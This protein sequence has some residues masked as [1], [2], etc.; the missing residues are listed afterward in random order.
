[1]A[2]KKLLFAMAL[3]HGGFKSEHLRPQFVGQGLAGQLEAGG[4]IHLSFGE[5][6]EVVHQRPRF[7]CSTPSLAACT[8]YSRASLDPFH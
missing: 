8:G 3:S 6:D 7:A 1:M 2:G 4:G 5:E